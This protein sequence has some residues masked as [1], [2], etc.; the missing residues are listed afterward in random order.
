M[1][2]PPFLAT[3]FEPSPGST[4]RSSFLCSSKCRTEAIKACSSELSA[5]QRAKSLKTTRVVDFRSDIRIFVN[6]QFFQLHPDVEYFEN[7]VEGFVITQLA[8]RTTL[9]TRGLKYATH[10]AEVSSRY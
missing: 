2:S 9:L 10:L 6:R 7:V 5:H 4:E 3:V 8:L 1:P